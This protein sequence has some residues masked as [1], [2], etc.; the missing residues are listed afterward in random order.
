MNSFASS[1]E[2]L[3]YFFIILWVF[4]IIFTIVLAISKGYNGFLAFLL[5]LFIPLLGSTI[6]IALLPDKKLFN[7][8]KENKI[9]KKKHISILKKCKKCDQIV[10]TAIY[11]NC[12][13]CDC[14]EF[15]NMMDVIIGDKWR[16]GKCGNLNDM[17]LLNCKNCNKEKEIE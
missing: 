10:D 9:E 1:I 2:G 11:T 6:I 5:G 15:I 17:Y 13:K 7:S 14:N 4:T 3:I 12:P 16:C 8:N